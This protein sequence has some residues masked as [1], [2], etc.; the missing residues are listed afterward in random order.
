MDRGMHVAD[1]PDKYAIQSETVH[2]DCGR[3]LHL[4]RAACCRLRFVLSEQDVREGVVQWEPG[5]PYMNRQRA[6]GYCIHCDSGKRG[7]QVYE[8]RPAV[9]RR[10]DCR[11]DR[12]IWLDFERRIVNPELLSDGDAGRPLSPQRRGRP[13]S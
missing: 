8:Q 5:A 4:C 6:D 13:A 9:C 10:Y 2:I 7:C 11:G 12:R 3:R 1:E